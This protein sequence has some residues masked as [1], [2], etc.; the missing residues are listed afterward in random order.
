MDFGVPGFVLIKLFIPINPAFK[1]PNKGWCLGWS[2]LL[3]NP[4]IFVN[5]SFIKFWNFF[6]GLRIFSCL[7]FF[8][9]IIL[10]IF[11]KFLMPYYLHSRL[12]FILFAK[13]PKP[14]V[15]SLHDNDLFRS[16]LDSSNTYSIFFM[17]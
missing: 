6:H 4:L 14:Y 3:Q 2:L 16:I 17:R 15:Y 1:I 7:I 10:Y 5:L 13:F 11:A 12:L 8:I 9:N